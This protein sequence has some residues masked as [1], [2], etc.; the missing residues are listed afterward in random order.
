MDSLLGKLCIL[1]DYDIPGSGVPQSPFFW[2]M[3][4]EIQ[5]QNFAYTTNSYHYLGSDANAVYITVQPLNPHAPLFSFKTRDIATNIEVRD[6]KHLLK[7]YEG[8]HL[9]FSG[10][11]NPLQTGSGPWSQG[12]TFWLNCITFPDGKTIKAN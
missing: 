8:Q 3:I 1:S 5:P 9:T 7:E 2:K 6:I 4:T 11:Y 10:T 12:P